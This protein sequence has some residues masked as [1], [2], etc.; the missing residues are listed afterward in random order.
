M[1]CSLCESFKDGSEAALIYINLASRLLLKICKIR[2]LTAKNLRSLSDLCTHGLA[3]GGPHPVSLL[4]CSILADNNLRTSIAKTGQLH[5]Q[6]AN[7]EPGGRSRA[8][9]VRELPTTN[10]REQ[11]ESV[12]NGGRRAL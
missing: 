7:R 6:H 8:R 11:L 3:G 10:T 5:T 4:F 2:P 9:K 12:E 1:A